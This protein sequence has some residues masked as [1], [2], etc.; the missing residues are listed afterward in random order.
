MEEGRSGSQEFGDGREFAR[1]GILRLAK[2][3]FGWADFGELARAH[4]GDARG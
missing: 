3:F 1:V 2:D 4:D